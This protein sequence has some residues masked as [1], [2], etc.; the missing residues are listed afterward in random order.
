MEAEL[1]RDC[2]L[3]LG[4][5]LDASLGGPD[6]DHA[7]GMTSPRRSLY[8]RHAAEK[9]MTF[10]KIFDAAAVS[11]CYERKES[12]VPQQA[13]ALANSELVLYESRRLAR[14]LAQEHPNDDLSFVAAAFLHVLARP[15]RSDEIQECIEFLQERSARYT[16]LAENERGTSAASDVSK[17]SAD[18]GLRARENLVHVL[19]NHHDFVT[20]Y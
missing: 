5:S 18:A 13:L 2:V 14:T 1:V 19:F 7:L 15:G 10:L 4:G 20:I 16:V 6:I 8:F 9:Q 3:Y 12:V 17:P 11:E